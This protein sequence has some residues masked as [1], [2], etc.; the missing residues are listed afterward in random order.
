M[1]F[2]KTEIAT[3]LEK[4]YCVMVISLPCQYF[5]KLKWYK[6]NIGG[7][8]KPRQ[9]DKYLKIAAVHRSHFARANTGIIKPQV[10]AS[11]PVPPH[12]SPGSGSLLLSSKLKEAITRNADAAS[13]PEELDWISTFGRRWGKQTRLVS[14]ELLSVLRWASHLRAMLEIILQWGGLTAFRHLTY[15]SVDS[16]CVNDDVQLLP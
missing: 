14:A 6:T 9:H 4:T 12:L 2:F 1:T 13:F 11:L 3:I 5:P 16:F 8:K 7:E 15:W 10:T